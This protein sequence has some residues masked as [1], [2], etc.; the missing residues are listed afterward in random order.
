[1][2]MTNNIRTRRSVRSFKSDKISQNTINELLV[3]A[4]CAPSPKNRQ[5]WEF[6]VCTGETKLKIV[7]VFKDKILKDLSESP[8]NKALQMAMETVYIMQ[9]APVLI[10]VYYDGICLKK[11]AGDSKSWRLLSPQVECC[12]IQAIGAAIQNL[13]LE[14][15]SRNISG[16]WVCDILYAYDEISKIMDS[17]KTFIAGVIL[18]YANEEPAMPKRNFNKIHWFQ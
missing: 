1:M 14:A 12:D 17:N 15:H 8:E 5:P 2:R 13:L 18:G 11:Y 10:L 3:S 7:K 9:V 4:M 16:L 6:A